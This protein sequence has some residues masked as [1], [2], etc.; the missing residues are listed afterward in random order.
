MFAGLGFKCYSDLKFKTPSQC[1]RFS[2]GKEQVIAPLNF[3]EVGSVDYR[4]LMQEK[5][6]ET[7]SSSL[8][9]DSI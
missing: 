1:S 5:I 8:V 6:L 2:F 4:L 3:K 7:F 9:K